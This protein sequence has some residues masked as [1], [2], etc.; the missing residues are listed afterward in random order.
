MIL[1]FRFIL[2]FLLSQFADEAF[3]AIVDKG[4]LDALME[5]KLGPELGLRYL[6]EV[7]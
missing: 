1:I 2:S 4:G 7:Q 3:D 5:P 6:L